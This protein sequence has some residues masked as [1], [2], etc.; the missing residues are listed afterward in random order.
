MMQVIGT[1]M[2]SFLMTAINE[3]M[4]LRS[5]HTDEKQ[6]LKQVEMTTKALKE[7]E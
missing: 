3:S 1:V 2:P 4:K 7:W 5:V 6:C